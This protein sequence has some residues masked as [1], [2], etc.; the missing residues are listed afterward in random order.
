MP[1]STRFGASPPWKNTF[2]LLQSPSNSPMFLDES[3]RFTKDPLA[4]TRFQIE[5]KTKRMMTDMARISAISTHSAFYQK[6]LENDD[7]QRELREQNKLNKKHQMK[8]TYEQVKV[9]IF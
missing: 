5:E 1:R 3:G 7:A 2:L 9:C 4:R 6:K 8:E